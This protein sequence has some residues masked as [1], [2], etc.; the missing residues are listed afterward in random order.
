MITMKIV[1]LL[2]LFCFAAYT[3]CV[4][5]PPQVGKKVEKPVNFVAAANDPVTGDWQGTGGVVAHLVPGG[6][7]AYQ[8]NLL[9]SFDAEGEPLAVLHGTRSGQTVTFTGDGWTASIDGTTFTGSKGDQKFALQRVTRASPTINAPPP[10]GAVVLFDGHNLDAWAKKAGKDWLAEDGPARWKI[11][12]G[13]AEVVPDTDCLITHQK[14]G[15]CRL[16]VEF[17][18]LGTPRTAAYSCRIATR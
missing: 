8:A 9:K 7:D 14:F 15:D 6:G 5:A 13:V 11:V 3:V 18:T 12:D 4:A 17:R 2:A 1:T 16:H 10:A